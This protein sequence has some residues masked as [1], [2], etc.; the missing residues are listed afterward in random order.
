MKRVR[1]Y[2]RNRRD[3]FRDKFR[4]SKGHEKDTI[5]TKKDT[6]D[7][8]KDTADTETIISATRSPP[9]PI[10][11]G[12]LEK[13]DENYFNRRQ[14]K[15]VDVPNIG[16]QFKGLDEKSKN[17]EI[18]VASSRKNQLKTPESKIERDVILSPVNADGTPIIISRETKAKELPALPPSQ[19]FNNMYD[20][21]PV[22]TVNT[23]TIK[24]DKS[25]SS[26]GGNNA[27]RKSQNSENDDK[28]TLSL[29]S[30]KVPE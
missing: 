24:S 12:H 4:S 23:Q 18:Y 16:N 26:A 5:D 19:R 14:R 29:D 30:N 1:R 13:L 17:D 15:V 8:V 11:K 27:R 2:T 10:T 9:E 25:S 7:T 3:A 21:P 6:I 28:K 20:K 22:K